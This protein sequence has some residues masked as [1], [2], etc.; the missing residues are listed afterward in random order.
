[1]DI[2]N[3]QTSKLFETKKYSFNNEYLNYKDS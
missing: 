1:M 3:I 2:V